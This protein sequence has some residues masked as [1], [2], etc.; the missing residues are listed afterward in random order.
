LG[1]VFRGTVE[2]DDAER[3][4]LVKASVAQTVRH[5]ADLGVDVLNDGE[6]GKESYSTYVRERL[7]GFTGEREAALVMTDMADYPDYL[8][9]WS[10]LHRE[11]LGKVL[12][13]PACV[14]DIKLTD[15]TAV[16]TDIENLRAGLQGINAED[17]FLSAASPG[18]IGAFF[19]N[20]HYP[21][22]EAYLGAIGEAMRAEYEAIVDAGFILQLDCPDLAMCRHLQFGDLSTEE[23][24][25]QAQ[26]AIAVLNHATANIDPDSMR[27][28]LC[29]GNYEGPHHHDI[30]LSDIVDV[31]LSARPN[32][33]VLES[34]NPRHDHEWRV[35]E[36]VKLPD[37]KVLMPG[38][39]DSTS[40]YIEHPEL[41]AQRLVRLAE[42]VG[43]ENVMAATDCGFATGALMADVD[44][45]IAWAKFESMAEGAR[46][47][48]ERLYR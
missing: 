42:L 41:V 44:P 8:N 22:R 12:G 37:G 40:N 14:G 15:P 9:R 23:F 34:A 36:N 19:A 39:V 20:H 4:E 30:N 35:F 26:L 47:A 24:R 3:A 16:Q 7:S 38:V 48:T 5:Q 25:E 18:V 11:E 10:T 43:P 13:P 46:L 27:L 29:W 17:V 33:I 1:A 32:G 6:M 21:D 28:H 45:A 2:L 31:V